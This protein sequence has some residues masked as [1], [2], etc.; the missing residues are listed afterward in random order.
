MFSPYVLLQQYVLFAKH[1]LIVVF[2]WNRWNLFKSFIDACILA[3]KIIVIRTQNAVAHLIF[4]YV[5]FIF[6]LKASI[7]FFLPVALTFSVTSPKSARIRSYS[8]FTI[9]EVGSILKPLVLVSIWLYCVDW[10]RSRPTTWVRCS[11]TAFSAGYRCSS[12][13]RSVVDN[14]AQMN[15]DS[16][17]PPSSTVSWSRNQTLR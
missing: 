3:I 8:T 10:N 6:N 15:P 7:K 5:H 9:S 1:D 16:F 12:L 17:P 13:Y 4:E 14:V 2:V 11:S